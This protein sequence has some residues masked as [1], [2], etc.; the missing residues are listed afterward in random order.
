MQQSFP[1][2]G[3]SCASC[4][5]HVTKALQRLE[6]VSEVN[7]NLATNT[8]RVS[9][10]PQLCTP[11]QMQQAVAQMGFELIIDQPVAT[12]A[13]DNQQPNAQRISRTTP[14]YDISRGV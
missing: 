4:S 5:A 8:A 7:V 2:K 3:M 10:A 11:E 6:G 12:P 9:Y 14:S 1:V 13:A